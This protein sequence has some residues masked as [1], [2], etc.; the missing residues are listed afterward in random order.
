MST[1]ILSLPSNKDIDNIKSPKPLSTHSS[2]QIETKCLICTEPLSKSP[3]SQIKCNGHSFCKPCLSSHTRVLIKTNKIENIYKCPECSSEFQT[4][5]I[6]SLLT[7]EESKSLILAT[8]HALKLKTIECPKCES[9]FE[10]TCANEQDCPTK[11]CDHRF[12]V[13]DFPFDKLT[14]IKNH[15]EMMESLGE[16]VSQC[17]GCFFP[18]VKDPN[19]CSHTDCIMPGCG[20]SFCFECC[21]IRSPTLAHGNHFHRPDCKFYTEYHGRDDRWNMNCTE[22]KKNGEYVLCRRPQQL[23]VPRRFDLD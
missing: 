23:K 15:I 2:P 18:Y 20:I 21:C 22:C 3:D 1:T 7:E 17:P 6:E 10:Y 13:N 19:S 12:K 14:E 4:F 11:G 9:L 8:L 5:T 16:Q